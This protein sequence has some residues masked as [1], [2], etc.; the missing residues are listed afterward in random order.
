[1]S[2][3]PDIDPTQH[4]AAAL[5]PWYVA[6]TLER[7]EAQEVERHLADCAACRTEL[8]D[9][10]RLRASLKTAFADAP[11][12]APDLLQRIRRQLPRPAQAAPAAEQPIVGWFAPRWWRPWLPAALAAVIV[13]QFG[14]MAWLIGQ[15]PPDS[16]PAADRIQSRSIPPATT[17]FKVGFAE[18][19]T[20]PQI[21]ALLRNI[22]G[23][24]SDGPLT[25]DFYLIEVPETDALAVD[26]TLEQLRAATQLVRSA[27]RA[28]P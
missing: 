27:E 3:T 26:R 20:E 2:H 5:L 22:H 28:H 7:P 4:P 23:R 24:I 12:P 14:A 15:L 11:R 8:E 18:R 19:A 10:R 1:M 17:R 16:P 9:V 6:G 13:A 25:G 21:R